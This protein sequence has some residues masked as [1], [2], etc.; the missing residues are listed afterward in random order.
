MKRTKSSS[1][2][3]SLISLLRM[4]KVSVRQLMLQ[5]W[6]RRWKRAVL[7]SDESDVEEFEEV[8]ACLC[9]SRYLT[10]NPGYL[11]RHACPDLNALLQRKRDY[12]RQQVRMCQE[13]F[14][15]LLDVIC[16][17]PV[18]YNNS[19]HLQRHP[20]IQLFIWLQAIGHDGN[21]LC[22]IAISG[23]SDIGEGTVTKY[24]ERVVVALRSVHDQF[25]R[26]PGKAARAKMSA[27]FLDKHG[28]YVVGC[29][30]GTFFYFNQAPAVDPE[31]FFTYKKKMYGLNVQLVCDLSWKII[32]Y[33]VGWP[34]CTADT[35]AFETSEFYVRRQSFFSDG[36]GLMADKGYTARMCVCVPWDEPEVTYCEDREE[37]DRRAAFNLGIK[38]GRILIER[39]NAMIK[40]RFTWT[41]GMRVQIKTDADFKRV[42]DTI[43]CIIIT[44]NFMMLESDVWTD[45]RQPACDR[46]ADDEGLAKAQARLARSAAKVASLCKTPLRQ[47]EL[48]ARLLRQTQYL[49]WH[50]RRVAHSY[51]S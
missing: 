13:S 14:L 51:F 8:R 22:S 32:G 1:K 25:V 15:R 12:F 2:R 43:I 39:V 16:D 28:L 35:Q 7:D 9:S 27:R 5:R 18:F 48:D 44:H 11:K 41:K 50:E 3:Q 23:Q 19:F 47:Q 10:R 26:W 30:D 46:W 24:S 40:N 29:L 36:E 49:E 33:V 45:V 17:N 31:I 37:R 20:G 4:V 42:N 21:G 34:G 38:K 6:R